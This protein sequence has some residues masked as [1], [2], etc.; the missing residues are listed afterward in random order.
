MKKNIQNVKMMT[1]VI[2]FGIV[3]LSGLIALVGI[4]NFRAE[5]RRLEDD[6]QLRMESLV[7]EMEEKVT[8]IENALVSRSRGSYYREKTDE[9]I[10]ESLDKFLLEHEL[11]EN[12][13]IDYCDP[14][15]QSSEDSISVVYFVSRTDGNRL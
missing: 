6:T 15:I 7:S 8:A 4:F 13:A 5:R 12:V 11:M 10:F 2:V 14:A 1:P 3:L 9:E